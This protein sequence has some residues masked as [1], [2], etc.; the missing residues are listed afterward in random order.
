VALKL[1][2]PAIVVCVFYSVGAGAI[3]DAASK[4]TLAALALLLAS[5]ALA[6]TARVAKYAVLNPGAGLHVNSEL[7]L[8]ARMGN[9]ASVIGHFTPLLH[10]R[11][12][13]GA[14]VKTLCLDRYT[15]VYA[16]F[17]LA[18]L[19]AALRLGDDPVFSWSLVGCSGAVLGMTAAFFVR[20]ALTPKT[21]LLRR[22]ADLQRTLHDATR[23]SRG[24]LARVVALSV[25]A[26]LIDCIGV[27]IALGA[28]G[29]HVPLSIV[30]VVW[31][32]GGSLSYLAF[33][34]IGP[35]EVATVVLMGRLAG[36]TSAACATMMILLRV[37]G[38]VGLGGVYAVH[39]V[40][41]YRVPASRGHAAPDA[42]A[43]PVSSAGQEP[44]VL[45]P[46]NPQP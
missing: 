5:R 23:V 39:L 3:V 33:M 7:F 16:T 24:A 31:A 42:A 21:R 43:P 9:E 20:L 28:L 45:I 14:V 19:G 29:A 12:R 35:A 4:L 25:V 10:P 11:H 22:L 36:V 1:L 38:L 32:I 27:Q 41:L 30:P 37:V 44:A 26:T 46:S 13:S 40:A 2:G 18:C 17:V 8:L 15:E 6:S 34:N